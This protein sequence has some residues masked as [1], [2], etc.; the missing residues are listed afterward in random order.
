MQ[1]QRRRRRRAA[2]A[3]SYTPDLLFADD[4][5]GEWWDITDPSRLRQ[6]SGGTTAVSALNDPVGYALGRVK[7][8]TAIQATAANRPFWNPAGYVLG[9]GAN[10]NWLTGLLGSVRGALIFVGTYTAAAADTVMGKQEAANGRALLGM[11]AAGLPFGGVGEQASTTILGSASILNARVMQSVDWN[12]TRVN[13]R[14]NRSKVYEGAQVGAVGTVTPYR[15]FG[16]NN[17]GTVNGAAATRGEHFIV[18]NRALLEADVAYL[19][20]YF[21]VE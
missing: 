20:D 5:L 21:G 1:D 9:D 10:D 17:N 19:S 15:L 7:G 16:N 13:L 12:E 2:R 8:L 14:V 11:T 3:S 4:E 18:L 6:L